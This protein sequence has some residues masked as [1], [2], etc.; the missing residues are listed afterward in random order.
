MTGYILMVP[1]AGFRAAAR[2]IVGWSS[3]VKR[4]GLLALPPMMVLGLAACIDV[5]IP[6]EGSLFVTG[7]PF[8]LGGTAAIVDCDG[9]RLVWY[10]DNGITYHLFQGTRLTNDEFDRVTTA[11]VS[12]RLEIATRQDLV[13]SCQIGTIVEVQRVLEIVE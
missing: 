11:G 1:A 4:I 7:E 10:G 13:V 2:R 6:G 5:A 8:V 9:P 3:R 12:S